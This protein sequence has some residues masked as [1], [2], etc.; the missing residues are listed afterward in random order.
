MN[1]Y[2]VYIIYKDYEDVYT[3]TEEMAEYY[4]GLVEWLRVKAGLRLSRYKAVRREE[5]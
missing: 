3:W 1:T 4:F 5:D 2:T